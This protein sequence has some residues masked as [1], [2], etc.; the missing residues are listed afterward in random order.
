M[1]VIYPPYAAGEIGVVLTRETLVD[2]TLT[3]YWLVK[4]DNKDVIL[5]LLPQDM[6]NLN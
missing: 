5:A 6:E 4:L 2:G 1:K 3:A